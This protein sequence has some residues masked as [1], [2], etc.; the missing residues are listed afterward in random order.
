MPHLLI[1]VSPKATKVTDTTMRNLRWLRHLWAVVWAL[2]ASVLAGGRTSPRGQTTRSV[3]AARSCAVAAGTSSEGRP[4][5]TVVSKR[6]QNSPD[7]RD[8]HQ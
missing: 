2:S 5:R 8:G 3:A 7:D 4:G 6:G 1:W